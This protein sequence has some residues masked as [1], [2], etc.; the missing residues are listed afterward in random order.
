MLFIRVAADELKHFCAVDDS[1]TVRTLNNHP[2]DPVGY[3]QLYTE[4]RKRG[5]APE[6]YAGELAERGLQL[7]WSLEE[8]QRP[9]SREGSH[10]LM[11]YVPPE[12]WGAAFT[13]DLYP[14]H[15]AQSDAYAQERNMAR[16]V[17]FFKATS[18][19]CVGP[20]DSVGSRSDT[21]AMIPEPELGIVLAQDGEVMG[22]TVVNDVSSRDLPQENPLFVT[23]S[24]T[25]TRC[26][27]LGPAIAPPGMV[28]DPHDL[29]VRCRVWRGDKILM[30]DQGNTGRMIRSFEELIHH[31]TRCNEI[32]TG[33]LLATGTAMRLPK[34][35]H[36]TAGDQI[37][38]EIQGIGRLA[39]S[40]V[41][42]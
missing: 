2:G 32:P 5:Q 21:V 14:N 28:G 30:D 27:S 23:Y 41:T 1:G 25:F 35:M 36:L 31:L 34:D 12:V 16:P 3:V 10:L 17:I 13:Y 40:V 24:K 29:E 19:R 20:N 8:L 42:V 7:P 26:V 9:P 38:I 39:N 4:A 33:T 11:P 6:S 37:E 22:F 18:H 15:S